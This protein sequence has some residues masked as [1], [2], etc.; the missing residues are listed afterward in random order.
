[1]YSLKPVMQMLE[2]DEGAG[3]EVSLETVIQSKTGCLSVCL[4]LWL[5]AIILYHRI[6]EDVKSSP[7][8]TLE[9]RRG[10]ES[11]VRFLSKTSSL[12]WLACACVVTSCPLHQLLQELN[13]EFDAADKRSVFL[14][15]KQLGVYILIGFQQLLVLIAAIKMKEFKMADEKVA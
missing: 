15:T 5:R 4:L 6:F 7:K 2:K 12:L 9:V 1:M 14:S 10:P 11:R 3:G 8:C 13:V